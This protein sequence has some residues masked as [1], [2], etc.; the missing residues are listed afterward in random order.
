MKEHRHLV[1]FLDQRHFHCQFSSNYRQGNQDTIA[2]LTKEVCNDVE[3]EPHL[4]KLTGKK[5]AKSTNVQEDARLDVSAR[6]FWINGQ[7]IRVFN[8]Y[9]PSH[10][11]KDISTVFLSNEK[12][13]KRAYNN[14]VVVEV[15]HGSFTPIVLTPYGGCSRETEKFF[16]PLASKIAKKRDLNE[17]AV[18]HWLRTKIS[19]T[20]LRSSIL[21]I[22]G[23]RIS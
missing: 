2:N 22:R 14:R 1:V 16:S 11:N 19:F 8:P 3:V 7:D 13:K 5:F 4:I 10:L 21:C 9:A 18:I 6:H 17:S 12:E 20:L 15:E 23:S